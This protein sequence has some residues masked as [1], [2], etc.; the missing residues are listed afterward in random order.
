M[1]IS[2]QSLQALLLLFRIPLPSW[3]KCQHVINS[4]PGTTKSYPQYM[5]IIQFKWQ[6]RNS[7]NSNNQ[8]SQGKHLTKHEFTNAKNVAKQITEADLIAIAYKQYNSPGCL[9]VIFLFGNP[10]TGP[11]I[12][13]QHHPYCIVCENIN[14]YYNTHSLK[15]RN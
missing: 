4:P 14:M 11:Y 12:L 1:S 3:L 8:L 7:K 13:N 15:C 9:Q 6:T 10:I 5:P 2:L